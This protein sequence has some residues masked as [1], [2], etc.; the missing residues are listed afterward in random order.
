MV[1]KLICQSLAAEKKTH[2]SI[3]I[4]CQTSSILVSKHV[5]K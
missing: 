2:M 1:I 4:E 5:N 3:Y